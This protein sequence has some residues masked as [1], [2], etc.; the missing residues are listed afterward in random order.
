MIPSECLSRCHG[1]LIIMRHIDGLQWVLAVMPLQHFPSRAAGSKIAL[2]AR[3]CTSGPCRL[4]C[5]QLACDQDGAPAQKPDDICMSW[6]ARF[7]LDDL[8]Q[9]CAKCLETGLDLLGV[10]ISVA[11]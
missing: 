9:N 6:V 5:M 7:V 4:L 10:V 2:K 3:T 8:F 11:L 1:C